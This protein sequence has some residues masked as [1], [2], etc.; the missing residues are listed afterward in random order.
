MDLTL[1]DEE[2]SLLVRVL[3]S[4]LDDLRMEIGRTDDRHLRDELQAQEAVLKTIIGR[5]TPQT[6]R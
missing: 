4:D 2:V 3:S 5:L 6:A 1:T